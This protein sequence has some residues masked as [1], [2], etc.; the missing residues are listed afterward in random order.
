MMPPLNEQEAHLWHAGPAESFQGLEALGRLLSPEEEARARRFVFEKDRAQFILGRGIMR[1]L[2][3]RYLGAD[4]RRLLLRQTPLGKPILAEAG[5]PLE[6][7]LSH[8]HGRILCGMAL[9]RRIGVDV[10][11]MRALPF[12]TLARH[13]MEAAEL[14]GFV[15]LGAG[16]K[17]KAF[18][19]A[20]T[21]KEAYLKALGRGLGCVAD[22]AR[23]PA[24]PSGWAVRELSLL[25][26]YAAAVAVEGAAPRLRCL[27]WP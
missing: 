24:A 12:D 25:P 8:S 21:R 1:S 27:P 17:A 5:G 13:V 18:Y 7:S 20:W 3:G 16:L 26:G 14:E 22:L 23:V 4:P 9:G 6:F 19:A 11:L 2:L 15:S 10:E